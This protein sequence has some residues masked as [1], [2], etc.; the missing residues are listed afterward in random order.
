MVAMALGVLLLGAA[1]WAVASQREAAASAARA[2]ADAPAALVA[3][4]VLL[5][6]VNWLL[7]SAVFWILT[8]R[9]GR[10]GPV[11]MV[12]LIGSAWLLNYVPARAGLAGRVA[13]HK[14]VNGIRVR[15]AGAVVVQS[16]GCTGVALAVLLGV[17]GVVAG[18]G[19]PA[20]MIAAAMAGAATVLGVAA[21]VWRGSDPTGRG[22][23][24]AGAAAARVADVAVWGVR[25][26]AVFALAGVP[27]SAPALG[28]VTAASMASMLLPVQVGVR[29][30]VVGVALGLAGGAA[31]AGGLVEAATPGL[32]V[33][34]IN[35]AAETLVAVPV[36]LWGTWWV[37]R[38]LRGVGIARGRGGS[39][40]GLAGAPGAMAGAGTGSGALAPGSNPVDSDGVAR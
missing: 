36:G 32:A 4:V 11:E 40:T 5:P 24:L 9:Y 38:R 23:R 34:L 25:Y 29:E 2:A 17:I 27:V 12:A 28:V 33:D 15:D 10:V 21:W 16:I 19:G 13:Y 3:A 6:L 14:A 30:W 8:G 22:W 1:V 20:W 7:T 18:A 26:A 37:V 31:G 35:R 39:E